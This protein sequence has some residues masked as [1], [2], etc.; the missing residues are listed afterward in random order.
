MTIIVQNFCE[1]IKRILLSLGGIEIVLI[2]YL[3][4]KPLPNFNTTFQYF[5]TANEAKNLIISH[6]DLSTYSML[7]EEFV[8]EVIY[9]LFVSRKKAG[10]LTEKFLPY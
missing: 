4:R 3:G 6:K 8:F 2:F 5:P 9:I 7:T 10:I 1:K